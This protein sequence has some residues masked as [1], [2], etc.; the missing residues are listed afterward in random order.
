MLFRSGDGEEVGALDVEDAD[1]VD[2]DVDADPAQTLT[3]TAIGPLYHSIDQ[4]GTH[5][6]ST[7]HLDYL[8]E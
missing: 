2:V 3:M 5:L 1:D 8:L 6:H 4:T 7:P